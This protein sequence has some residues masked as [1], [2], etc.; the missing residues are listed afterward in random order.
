MSPA[1]QDIL[2]NDCKRLETALELDS[3]SARIEVQCLLQAALQVNRAWLF[4]H[5]EQPL[6]ADQ[7]ARYTALLERRLGG[8]P[9]AYLLGEREFYGLIFKVSPA[10]LIP[11]PETELL[12][13]LAL[14]RIPL[15]PPQPSDETPSHSTRLSKNDNQ[16]A[17]Y[18]AGGRGSKF[19]VL[20]LGTGSGAIALSIAHAHPDAEVVA[21]DASTAALEIAQFNTQ[22]LGLGNV[23]LLHSDWFSALQGERFDM[24][25]SNPP[26]IA[27][28]DA[29]LTQGD[30]RFEPC[31]ALASGV[32]G[33]DD[34]RRICAQAKAHLNANGWMLFE[35]GYD[36]AVRVRALLQQS[37]FAGI[38]SA[39]D[40][41]GIERVSGGC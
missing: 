40:L 20:D 10:T 19:R 15:P 18:P 7:L 33:L 2:R 37:G 12:V 5:P 22:Q 14:E 1:I 9:I 35:H 31:S 23:R 11:R 34:I 17:G 25:V 32:D 8:E 24:I 21:V 26:Y 41:S 13:E 29:H 36:Q 4:T 16:V 27:A 28:A 30:V 6:D 3:G 39:R 38:F